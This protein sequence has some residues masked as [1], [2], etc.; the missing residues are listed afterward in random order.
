MA[1]VST[2]SAPPL[3]EL[4]AEPTEGASP[5][6]AELPPPA[7]WA[8]SPNGGGDY[9]ENFFF[10]SASVYAFPHSKWPY[11]ALASALSP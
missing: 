11:T 8:T 4:S 10:N 9:L 7:L 1:S 6:Y 5:A 2:E 3:G